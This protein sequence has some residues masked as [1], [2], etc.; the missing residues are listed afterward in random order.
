MKRI[1]TQI[2]LKKHPEYQS[3]GYVLVNELGGAML[4]FFSTEKFPMEEEMT[5]TFM[6]GG[7]EQAYE[8]VM[9]HLHEQISS[10]RIMT[11]IPSENNPFPVRKFYR[12]YAKVSKYPSQEVAPDETTTETLSPVPLQAVPDLPEVVE[13]P[14]AETLPEVEVKAA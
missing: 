8:V 9:S 7:K 13:Q 10:G 2:Q 6:L 12:C 5:L 4:S 14:A 11:S 1:A 3:S